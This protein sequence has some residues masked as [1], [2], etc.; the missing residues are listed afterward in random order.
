MK[1]SLYL[2]LPLQYHNQGFGAN[3]NPLYAGQGLKGHTADDWGF[4][5]D[6]P[7]RNVADEAYCYSVM[8]K[9]NSDPMK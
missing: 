2:P 1:L 8:N 5:F 9:D 4:A 3:A 7:I 6:A